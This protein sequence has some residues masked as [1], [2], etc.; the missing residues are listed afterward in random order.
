[1]MDDEIIDLEQIY[2]DSYRQN[3]TLIPMYCFEVKKDIA[4]ECL[5][6]MK[7][8]INAQLFNNYNHLKRCKKSEGKV[9][10]LVGFC[11]KLPN[12][13]HDKL[14]QIN[15]GEDITIKKVNVSKHSPMTKK[16]CIEWST[17][18]PVYYRKPTNDLYTLTKEEIKKYIKFLNISI[19]IGKTF[20]TCQSGCVLTY[21]DEII[22]CSGDNI[23]NHPLQH[24]V[25]LAIEEVSYKLRHIWQI[26]KGITSKNWE[27]Y[28][29]GNPI[30]NPLSILC[31]S[32]T[33]QEETSKKFKS[34]NN[35]K[36]YDHVRTNSRM[37]TIEQ[38]GNT[39]THDITKDYTKNV[40]MYDAINI[41]Q[42]LCTNCYA[43]LSHEPCFMCSMAMIHSR[44]KCVIFDEVNKANGALFSKEKLH[45]IK[46]LNHHFK[47]YKTVKKKL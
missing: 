32:Q 15:N 46:S 1:M 28:H 44:I 24:S 33:S 23:K 4:K 2:P 43:Y 45:C 5:N 21:N 9:Q 3:V 10:I 7:N 13:L 12:N 42:Y 26:K 11:S 20:G 40:E 8:F 19:N 41:D 25:M 14:I 22:A 6:I 38:N 29:I 31:A 17:H 18:W 36:C 35:E 16:Q 47:V 30:N 37:V 39:V 27:Y 34:I